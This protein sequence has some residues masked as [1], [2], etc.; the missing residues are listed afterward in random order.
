MNTIAFHLF[1][2]G[3]VLTCGIAILGPLIAQDYIFNG[4]SERCAVLALMVTGILGL[5]LTRL[6]IYLQ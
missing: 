2:I 3:S 5:V 1:L 6:G 4:G